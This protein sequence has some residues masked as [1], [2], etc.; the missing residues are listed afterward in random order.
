MIQRNVI[1]L[2]LDINFSTEYILQVCHINFS[3]PVPTEPKNKKRRREREVRMAT[4]AGQNCRALYC[5]E[6]VL[7][8][9]FLDNRSLLV[10]ERSWNEVW[11]GLAPPMYRHRYGT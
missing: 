11:K 2:N 10:V 1:L 5:N 7:H 8:V 6:P 4:P 9:Q 3:K